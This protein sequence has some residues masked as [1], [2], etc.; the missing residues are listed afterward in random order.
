MLNLNDY[1]ILSKEE[2]ESLLNLLSTQ[3]YTKN[4]NNTHSEIMVPNW[5]KPSL[6]EPKQK[7]KY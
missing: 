2:F 3:L 7:T 1:I 4:L 6:V 5:I